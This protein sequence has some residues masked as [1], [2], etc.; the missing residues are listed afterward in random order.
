MS[1]RLR[2]VRAAACVA[3]HRGGPDEPDVVRRISVLEVSLQDLVEP[4]E[5]S[6]VEKVS[7]CSDKVLHLTSPAAAD[8]TLTK[9]KPKRTRQMSR[10]QTHR[11]PSRAKGEI[12][13]TRQER[14]TNAAR[15]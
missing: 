10:W 4:L 11:E 1:L 7:F 8:N 6:V 2:L 14:V 12:N 15:R 9:H 3:A 13:T 5:T